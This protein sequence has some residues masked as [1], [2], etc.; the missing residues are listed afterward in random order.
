VSRWSAVLQ[1]T[2]FGTGCAAQSPDEAGYR[3]LLVVFHHSVKMPF[4]QSQDRIETL[5]SLAPW[6]PFT[7]PVRFRR[8]IWRSSTPIPAATSSNDAPCLRSLS[9]IKK[10]GPLPNGVTLQLLSYP[11]ICRGVCFC[12]GGGST[13]IGPACRVDRESIH[14]AYQKHTYPREDARHQS[15]FAPELTYTPTEYPI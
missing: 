11:L 5:S 9:R 1:A 13:A 4:A 7:A 8:S 3:V 10:R 14:L 2:P 12:L 6:K 15:G